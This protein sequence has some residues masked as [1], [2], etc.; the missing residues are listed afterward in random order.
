M[1]NISFWKGTEKPLYLFDFLRDPIRGRKMRE[2]SPCLS[3]LLFSELGR[4]EGVPTTFRFLA[5]SLVE[6]IH[7]YI[8]TIEY[9]YI[10]D[11]LL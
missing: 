9:T 1:I 2:K 5:L 8:Y 11:R 3:S 4:M 7:F 6:N 10:S